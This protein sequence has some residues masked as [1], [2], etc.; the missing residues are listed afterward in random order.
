MKK[1]MPEFAPTASSSSAIRPEGV[2][3][4]DWL[5]S[6]GDALFRLALVRVGRSDLAED[7]VQD[8]LL[9]AWKAR[10]TF[11]GRSSERT[12]LIAIL[13]RKI[14]DHFRNSWRQVDFPADADQ[15]DM[16]EGYFQAGEKAGHWDPE[17]APSDWGRNPEL[18]LQNSQLR[19]VLTD[20][21]GKLPES[22]AAVFVVREIDGMSTEKICQEFS[23]SPSNLWVILH[24]ARTRL[25]RCLDLNWFQAGDETGRKHNG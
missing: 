10:D 15:D 22:L 1:A 6:H 11:A 3:P 20:C 18:S 21:V 16:M 19:Q 13:K 25:R 17:M 8:T 9:A 4:S 2:S 5:E 24:R 14:I 12:W 7:L 23:L